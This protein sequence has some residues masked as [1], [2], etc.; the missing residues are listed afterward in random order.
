MKRLIYIWM[1]QEKRKKGKQEGK[2]Q[3]NMTNVL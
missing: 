3:Q 1:T 2:N